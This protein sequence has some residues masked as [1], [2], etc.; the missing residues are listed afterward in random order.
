MEDLFA[1]IPDACR[2]KQPLNLPEPLSEWELDRHMDG[3]SGTTAIQ[4][5]Y[6]NFMGSSGYD[7]HISAVI[8]HLLRRGELLA[9]YTPYQ[10]E[11][12]QGTLQTIYEYQ[13]LDAFIAVMR[14][15]ADEA[16]QRPQHVRQAPHHTRHRRLD[17]TLAVRKPRLHG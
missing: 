13:T 6:M 8:K 9:A 15:I 5:G 10:V 7:H 4:P 14:T 2:R 3:L 11:V 17:D 12:S 1:H 16:E